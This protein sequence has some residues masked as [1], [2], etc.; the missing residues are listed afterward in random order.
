M[1]SFVL[2]H[3]VGTMLI[4]ILGLPLPFKLNSFVCK[5]ER[6]YPICFSAF[7]L[8]QIAIFI[9]QSIFNKNNFWIE[10]VKDNQEPVKVTQNDANVNKSERDLELQQSKFPILDMFTSMIG[11]WYFFVTVVAVISIALFVMQ[12]FLSS[13]SIQ[14]IS[15]TEWEF[16]NIF[17]AIFS[18]LHIILIIVSSL[19]AEKTFWYVPYKMGYFKIENHKNNNLMETL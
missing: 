5:A 11:K 3:F 13:S 19:Q 14:C 8:H 6:V 17:G 10:G 1:K 2:L 12:F 7:L 18:T 15:A 9:T 16:L 4:F